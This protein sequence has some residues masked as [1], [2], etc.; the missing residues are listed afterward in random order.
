MAPVREGIVG[1]EPTIMGFAVHTPYQLGYILKME[2]VGI[3]PTGTALSAQPL[4][5]RVPVRGGCR[6][7]I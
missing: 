4:A 1:L 2:R 6:G 5:I 3:E 7:R